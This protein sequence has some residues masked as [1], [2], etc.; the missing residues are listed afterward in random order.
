MAKIIERNAALSDTKQIVDLMQNAGPEFN[1]PKY[2]E[3]YSWKYK[4][5]YQEKPVPIWVLED[6]KQVVGVMHAIPA[7]LLLNGKEHILYWGSDFYQDLSHKGLGIQ[8][9]RILISWRNCKDIVM[10]KGISDKG[11]FLQKKVGFKD[12]NT[13]FKFKVM[14]FNPEKVIRHYLKYKLLSIPLSLVIKPFLARPKKPKTIIKIEEID[15]FD[16]KF[17]SFWEKT[18]KHYKAI[19]KRD[20]KYLK[21]RFDD[22][23]KFKYIKLMAKKNLL[24]GYIIGRIDKNN[25]EFSGLKIGFISDF[26][27]NPKNKDV[28]DSLIYEL[29]KRFEK[30]KVDVVVVIS[31]HKVFNKFLKRL[32]FIQTRRKLEGTYYINNDKITGFNKGKDFFI[33]WSDGDG[34]MI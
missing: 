5:S 3:V 16:K 21:W 34:D 28:F 17:D 11:Y 32:G 23:P 8:M 10:G 29:L 27:M 13:S 9:I 18:S 6:N 25:R 2:K 15:S 31:S 22:H 30:E 19:V 24:E 20:S 1:F 7:K 12:I 4:Y 26:L 33:T 14:I